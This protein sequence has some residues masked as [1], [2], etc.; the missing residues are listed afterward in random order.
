VVVSLGFVFFIA[1]F[2]DS[3][4]LKC[5]L[6]GSQPGFAILIA[7]LVVAALIAGWVVLRPLGRLQRV[8]LLL[9]FVVFVAAANIT[10]ML[11]SQQRTTIMFYAAPLAVPLIYL[12]A[13]PVVLRLYRAALWRAMAVVL[14]LVVSILGY[15]SSKLVESALQLSREHSLQQSL[16]TSGL[17]V[18]V[19]SDSATRILGQPTGEIFYDTPSEPMYIINFKDASLRSQIGNS[20]YNPETCS[21][22]YEIMLSAFANCYRLGRVNNDPVYAGITTEEIFVRHG[23][24]TVI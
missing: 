10:P 18:Y 5:T 11:M 6:I 15:Y 8:L 4:A 21:S 7:L 2:G 17:T 12:V 22:T 9:Y 20:R 16:N 24:T 23:K 3:D 14:L 13:A 1:C 19:P